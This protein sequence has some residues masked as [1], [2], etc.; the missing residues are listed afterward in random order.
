MNLT[1]FLKVEYKKELSELKFL[2]NLHDHCKNS[3]SVIKNSPLYIQL[4]T[5]EDFFI[6]RPKEK[7][8]KSPF[9]IDK[10]IESLNNWKTF[11]DR[12]RCVKCYN[13][14]D[15]VGNIKEA[16][17]VIPFDNS[18]IGICSSDSFYRSF[19]EFKKY[20]IERVDNTGISNWFS[21]ICSAIKAIDPE[22]KI[23]CDIDSFPELKALMNS[24]DDV[25]KDNKSSLL[26]KLKTTETL[27]DEETIVIRDL[28]SRHITTVEKYLDEKLDPQINGFSTVRIDSLAKSKDDKE[29][30]T[31]SPCL[32]IRRDAYIEMHKRGAVK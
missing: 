28:L 4:E 17:V 30:W 13:S 1:E 22:L 10:L 16:F 5:K 29:L 19:K 20:G 7:V 14:L 15:R 11:P 2:E 8:E 26:N 31:E 24:I 25:L 9:W 32:L 21:L 27:S 23:K 3:Y 6:I 18:R 12:K